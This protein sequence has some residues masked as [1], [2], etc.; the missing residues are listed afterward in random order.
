MRK[1]L[2]RYPRIQRDVLWFLAENGPSSPYDVARREGLNRSSVSKALERLRKDGRVLV[3]KRR[4]AKSGVKVRIYDLSI[5]GL[6]EVLKSC[7]DRDKAKLIIDNNKEKLPLIFGKWDLFRDKNVED[8]AFK[9]LKNFTYSG[10][11]GVPFK[12]K[13]GTPSY[14]KEYAEYFQYSFYLLACDILS[15]EEFD[16]WLVVIAMEEDIIRFLIDQIRKEKEV[17]EERVRILE[18][19]EK[20]LTS[21]F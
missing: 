15:R 5:H 16:R 14:E 10:W 11:V 20:R 7:K 12:S 2:H 8:I 4:R 13:I 1:T 18:E 3:V 19:I 17:Y 21:T 9:I 6:I